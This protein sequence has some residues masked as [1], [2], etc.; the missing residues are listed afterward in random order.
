MKK[1]LAVALVALMLLGI[2]ACGA[3]SAPEAKYVPNEVTVE[4]Y[5]NGELQ[6][7]QKMEYTYDENWN[8]TEIATYYDGVLEMTTKLSGYSENGKPAEMTAVDASGQE[9]MSIRYTYDSEDRVIKQE[10]VEND[11]VSQYTESTYDAIGNL[12]TQTNYL[13]IVDMTTLFEYS[14]DRDGNRTETKTYRNGELVS[15]E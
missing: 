2:T 12:A 1:L 6:G 9:G 14:Y 13:A 4:I 8:T 11:E 3:D 10:T 15:V 7:A 5:F